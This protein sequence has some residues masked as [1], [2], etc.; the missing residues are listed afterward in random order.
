MPEKS[1]DGYLKPGRDLPENARFLLQPVFVVPVEVFTTGMLARPQYRRMKAVVEAVSGMVELFPEKKLVIEHREP[2]EGEILPASV[3]AAAAARVA[4]EAAMGE[5]REG[6][7]A[8]LRSAHVMA[9]GDET[10][11]TWRVWIVR[12]DSLEDSL[13]GRTIRAGVLLSMMLSEDMSSESISF[14]GGETE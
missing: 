6:W 7:K 11:S 9:R 13:T 12:G 3:K 2:P 5:G 8:L 14:E 10:E 4:E 1:R